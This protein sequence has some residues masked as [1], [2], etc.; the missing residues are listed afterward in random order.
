MSCHAPVPV[1]PDDEIDID[2]DV[3]VCFVVRLLLRERCVD[4]RLIRLG[5]RTQEAGQLRGTQ[6]NKQTEKEREIKTSETTK[7]TNRR[8]HLYYFHSSDLLIV[9]VF[10]CGALSSV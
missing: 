8:N 10:V 4:D 7:Q 1:V 5:Q 9:S 3:R 2:M 6:T